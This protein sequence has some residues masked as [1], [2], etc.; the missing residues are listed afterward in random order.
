MAGEHDIE[1]VLREFSTAQSDRGGWDDHYERLAEI[2]LPRRVGFTST[3]V[4]GAR[5]TDKILDST[6]VQAR[7]S[8]STA[9]D[10]LLKPKTVR[11]MFVKPDDEDLIDD[12]EVKEWLDFVQGRM[13]KRIYDTNARFAQAT[14]EVDDDLVTFGTGALS[15]DPGQTS[16]EFASHHLKDVYLQV[17]G[18]GRVVAVFIMHVWTAQQAKDFFTAKGVEHAGVTVEKALGEEYE[19]NN[20]IEF[21]HVIMPNQFVI[22]ENFNPKNLPFASLWIE[23]NEKELIHQ[24]GMHEFPMA[25]P[26]WDTA[27][28]E[29]YGRSPA[30][31]ALPD[32][33][34]LQAQTRT[35]L[36]AGQFAVLPPI[37]APSQ[38]II[39]QAKLKSAGITYY[40]LQATVGQG[41]RQPIFSLDMG[42]NMPIGR[43]MQNDTRELI[44]AAF[45]KNV[46]NLPVNGP[47]MTATEVLER[48]EEFVRVIGPV[49][50]RLESEY[51]APIV[52]RVFGIMFRNNEFGLTDRNIVGPGG[53]ELRSI[54]EALQGKQ[55]N[56]EF[57][58]PVERVRKQVE[59]AAA[60]KTV[61]ELAGVAEATQNPSGLD[62]IDHD[63][64]AEL[65]DEANA[66]GILL[67]KRA[68]DK[69]RKDRA[70]QQQEAQAADAERAIAAAQ[71]A[72][73]AAGA[74]NEAGIE[75]SDMAEALTNAI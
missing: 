28:G 46:L 57:R 45:F 40:D 9:V 29:T 70:E 39:G 36:K 34:T 47:Q 6:P 74:F 3:P 55:I 25:T 27:S 5:R 20:K 75:G 11:W 54:P 52:E 50:G 62:H 12:P 37:F 15:I 68:V 44:W 73:Q 19:Q 67:D 30:M 49:F 14:G 24:G 17:D 69:M 33:N 8:L 13:F 48:K 7:R 32:A 53:E 42:S 31:V 65:L 4:P 22:A 1:R 2:M 71:Q 35:L 64:L 16:L 41:S 23:V 72:G 21:V 38:S 56:F 26:R 18:R 58:S 66:S 59:A 63:K 10:G 43:E 61:Q 51:L 60:L